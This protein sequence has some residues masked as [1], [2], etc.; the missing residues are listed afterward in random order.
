MLILHCFAPSHRTALLSRTCMTSP[1]STT[2]LSATKAHP[3]LR[4]SATPTTPMIASLPP[5]CAITVDEAARR[6]SEIRDLPPVRLVPRDDLRP[7][8]CL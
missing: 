6:K 5:L 8:V 3:G 7:P 4:P 2:V 1:K